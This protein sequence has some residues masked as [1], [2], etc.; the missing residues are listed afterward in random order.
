MNTYEKVLDTTS[1]SIK[2][3]FVL[4]RH[5][6]LRLFQ[7]DVVLFEEQKTQ[8][9]IVFLAFIAI[10]S[11]RLADAILRRYLF[12][13]DEGTSWVEKNYF[14]SYLMVLMGFITVLEWDVL[15]PDR[16]DFSNLM[17]LPVKLRAFFLAKF[18]SLILFVGLFSL[19]AN[20]LSLFVFYIY[21]PRWQSPSPVYG[22]RFMGSHLLSA[23]CSCFFIL[24]F[25]ALLLG[26][27]INI[28]GDRLF[29]SVSLYIRTGL[30]VILVFLLIL[31]FSESLTVPYSLSSFTE[32]KENSSSFFYYYPPM[33]F[34]GFYESLLGNEDP[35]FSQLSKIALVALGLS[36][37][38]FFLTS[39]FN[40]R[41]YLKKMEEV[42]KRNPKLVKLRRRIA[43]FFYPIFL[44]SSVEKAVFSFFGATVRRSLVHK[45]RL[46]SFMAVA[47]GMILIILVSRDSHTKVFSTFDRTLLSVPLILA[48]F[49]VIG[50]R[51]VVKI[52][53]HLEANWIF[54]MTESKDKKMYFAGL[55][56][57]IFFFALLPLFF[58]IF[59]FY[60][61][62]WDLTS[63]FYHCLYGL[64]VS[65][66]LMELLF[67]QFRKIPFT[68]SHLPGKEKLHVYWIVYLLGFILYVVLMSFVEVLLFLKPSRFFVFYGVLLMMILGVRIYQNVFFYKKVELVFEEELEP[69]MLELRA[70]VDK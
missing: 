19:G 7:N 48:F 67:L 50:L 16:R 22:L 44:R 40:Y 55:R 17:S 69:V 8:K 54:R 18:T 61:S 32:L 57:G 28:L 23:F 14:L 49:L 64:S 11:A 65:V 38:A 66:L 20:A 5:F 10:F 3:F 1:G 63:A 37:L 59:V 70:Q 30:L 36:I 47:L 6:F 29:R 25:C 41:R 2:D 62:I 35:F 21:L 51:R 34:T 13:A 24:F 56:K 42:K 9:I 4:V 60:S 39:V 31:F 12:F 46:A 15:F 27:L 26:V 68:C 52:P 45:M 43:Q 58:C 33:W 53:S